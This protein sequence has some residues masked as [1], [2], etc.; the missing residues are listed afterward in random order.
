MTLRSAVLT[1]ASSLLAAADSATKHYS[2]GAEKPFQSDALGI[3]LCILASTVSV[4]GVNLQ[5]KSHVSEALLP[6]E[7]QR[8]YL[9]RPQ[10]WFGFSCVVF[11]A[12]G[13]FV[14]FGFGQVIII[15][16]VGGATTLLANVII[17]R[18]WNQ[19][20]LTWHDT[21][22]V[23]CVVAAAIIMSANSPGQFLGTCK[24][25][26][27]LYAHTPFLVYSGFLGVSILILLSMVAGEL[28]QQMRR[29]DAKAR[30]DAHDQRNEE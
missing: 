28:R 21:L 18:V 16:S 22:G 14:A 19:E 26:F 15:A 7:L 1:S 2:G 4:F 10:W 24:E 20:T 8:S 17:A 12:V 13:D 27:A 23:S 3:A 9:I 29:D 6:G 11:G 30:D 25:Y 5:K